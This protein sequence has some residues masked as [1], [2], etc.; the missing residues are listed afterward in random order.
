MYRS[1]DTTCD[2]LLTKSIEYQ[3]ARASSCSKSASFVPW[4]CA[5]TTVISAMTTTSGAAQSRRRIRAIVSDVSDVASGFSRTSMRLKP[6]SRYV[7]HHGP[8]WR[9]STVDERLE[10]CRDEAVNRRRRADVFADTYELRVE[11]R[12]LE[13]AAVFEI[14]EH[15]RLRVRGHPADVFE[16][17]RQRVRREL[18]AFRARDGHRFHH[19][20][21]QQHPEIFVLSNHAERR[22]GGRH[23]PAERRQPHE[24]QPE[25]VL[26]TLAYLRVESGADAAVVQR[27]EP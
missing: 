5:D 9:R 14:F 19:G 16:H 4:A 8:P 25:F 18:N 12:Q 7:T 23:H 10:D 11:P 26:D 22:S 2:S 13:P 27:L 21:L 15:R 3:V 1:S 6:D 20:G 17:V 24:L